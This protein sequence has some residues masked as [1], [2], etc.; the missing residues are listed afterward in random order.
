MVTATRQPQEHGLKDVQP[1]VMYGASPRASINLILAGKALAFV[2]GR[3]YALPQDVEDIAL[4]VLRHRLV[5]TYEALSDNVSADDLLKQMLER[6]PAPKVPLHEPGN[7][8]V[9]A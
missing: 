6:I 3:N 2:R 8:R 5:L 4:D 9:R 1:Y 7:N